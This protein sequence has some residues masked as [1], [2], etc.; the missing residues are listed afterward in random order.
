MGENMSKNM[1]TFDDKM[2][3]SKYLELRKIWE[4]YL[5][6]SSKIELDL[7]LILEKNNIEIENIIDFV[8]ED[9]FIPFDS[10]LKIQNIKLKEVI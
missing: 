5:F 8:T 1:N 4:K 3:E 9:K 6:E 10:V 2:T 7:K